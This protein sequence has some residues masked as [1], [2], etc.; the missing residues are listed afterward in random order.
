[1]LRIKYFPENP[2][3]VLILW[4][5]SN[6]AWRAIC[7]LRWDNCFVSMDNLGAVFIWG[8]PH[9]LKIG[10]WVGLDLDGAIYSTRGSLLTGHRIE[11]VGDD[12]AK[13]LANLYTQES[14]ND[15]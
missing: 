4:D 12:A 13:F 11:L 14:I 1:M 2:E 3:D 5:G 8:A 9:L 10:Y 7:D 6:D 15:H